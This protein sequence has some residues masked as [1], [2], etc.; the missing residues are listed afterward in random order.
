MV[1]VLFGTIKNEFKRKLRPNLGLSPK[2]VPTEWTR[3][4]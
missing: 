1:D 4:V 2:L 3:N